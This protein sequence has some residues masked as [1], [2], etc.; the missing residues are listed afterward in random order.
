MNPTGFTHIPA[1]PPPTLTGPAP[2]DR[3]MRIHQP[4]GTK[5]TQEKLK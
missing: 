1:R 3:R 2:R 4:H 5:L